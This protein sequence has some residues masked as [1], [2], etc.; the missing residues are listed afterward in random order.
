M[1]IGGRVV[2]CAAAA[3]G[4]SKA[5]VAANLNRRSWVIS[6]VSLLIFSDKDYPAGAH[7]RNHFTMPERLAAR[8]GHCLQT[9]RCAVLIGETIRLAQDQ[10]RD[11]AKARRERWR[12]FE[13]H[14]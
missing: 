9:C 8:R 3:A 5:N 12:L 10:V 14:R 1:T 4:I 11:E 13:C 6:F 7:A 2:V